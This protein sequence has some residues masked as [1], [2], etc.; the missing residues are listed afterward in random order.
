M[1]VADLHVVGVAVLEPKADAPLVVD[2]DRVLAFSV[3]PDS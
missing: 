1:V 3:A 2:G